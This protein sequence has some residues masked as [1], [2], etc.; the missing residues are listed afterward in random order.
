MK[1]L[2]ACSNRLLFLVPWIFLFTPK[3]GMAQNCVWVK[4]ANVSALKTVTDPSGNVYVA[5][6]FTAD[7]VSFGSI[8]LR[9]SVGPSS[10][11]NIFLVKCDS[12]GT[13][14]WARSV[15]CSAYAPLFRGLCTDASGNV[16]ITG[17]YEYDAFFGTDT[18]RNLSYWM[19]PFIAKYDSAGNKIWIRDLGGNGDFSHHG[20]DVAMGISCNTSGDVY[21][22]GY[23]FSDTLIAGSFILRK[24]GLW[25]DD[26]DIFVVKLASNGTVTWAKCFGGNSIEYANDVC[27][28]PSG[29]VYV[30]GSYA[31]NS[32]HNNGGEP[33]SFGSITLTANTGDY[34]NMFVAKFNS[35]GTALWAR[36]AG[37]V[38]SDRAVSVAANAAGA[39]VTGYFG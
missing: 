39:V 5:G 12:A 7:S 26:A 15:G 19:E 6:T 38:M 20:S 24:Y 32:T 21:I 11:S 18:L 33:V 31:G 17:A 13:P 29:N 1:K 35:S 4:S 2:Y 23:F 16:L 14:I 9:K 36:G 34:G 22:A 37:G 27:V 3:E 10:M 30:A 28:D 25:Y 8:T